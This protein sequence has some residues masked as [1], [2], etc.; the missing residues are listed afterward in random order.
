MKHGMMI[1]C[2]KLTVDLSY[3]QKQ[4]VAFS[5]RYS[6]SL[7][8]SVVP[9][10]CGVISLTFFSSPGLSSCSL[11]LPPNGFICCSWSL[12]MLATVHVLV[13]PHTTILQLSNDQSQHSTQT[14]LV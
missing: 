5:G 12:A 9:S 1:S 7:F 4:K 13:S 2:P 6:S 8:I 14:F 3:P 10:N 11:A